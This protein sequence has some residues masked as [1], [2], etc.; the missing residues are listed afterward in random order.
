MG[1]LCNKKLRSVAK[2][3]QACLG[4]ASPYA[5]CTASA[6]GPAKA[7]DAPKPSGAMHSNAQG[8]GH[9]TLVLQHL[10]PVP[11]PA[12]SYTSTP[13]TTSQPQQIKQQ[14]ALDASAVGLQPA[15]L[16]QLLV[17]VSYS[18]M[19]PACTVCCAMSLMHDAQA[20]D[21]CTGARCQGAF[22]SKLLHG[23][24]APVSLAPEVD[25]R[26]DY[27]ARKGVVAVH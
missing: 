8:H 5:G 22:S 18:S 27:D 12:F 20:H 1:L 19:R 15:W 13:C 16:L 3:Y 9:T 14:N 25:P 17:T 26:Q 6:T 4:Q 11:L 21:R 10:L 23:S 2:Q 7:R 24:L